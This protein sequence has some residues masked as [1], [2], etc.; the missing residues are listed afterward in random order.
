M[1]KKSSVR[2]FVTITLNVDHQ[3]SPNE[4]C[5]REEV[6]LISNSG[7]KGDR[8]FREQRDFCELLYF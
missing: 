8:S 7:F 6:R 3:G 5:E 2:L 1:N 4:E